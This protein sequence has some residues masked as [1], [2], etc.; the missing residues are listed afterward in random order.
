MFL[1]N[2]VFLLLMIAPLVI[3]LLRKKLKKAALQHSNLGV[4]GGCQ[5]FN[6]FIRLLPKALIVILIMLLVITLAHPQVTRVKRERKL[7]ARE[8]VLTVD[9]SGS[10]D[11]WKLRAVI[12]VGKRFAL[13][14]GEKG[15]LV[16]VVIYGGR[17]AYSMV[18]PTLDYELVAAS[19]DNI[20]GE[21][22]GVMTPIGEG[23][24]M[25]LITL[26]EREMGEDFDLNL[27]RDSLKTEEKLYV[28]GLV[29]KIGRVKNKLIVLF[30]DGKHNSG[31]L[32]PREAFW[33]IRK[34]GVRVYFIAPKSISGNWAVI[35]RKETI[36]TG[37]RYYE[38]TALKEE[39]ISKF[40][41]EINKI[42]K[43]IVVIEEV[44]TKEDF[45][46]PFT[47]AILGV[48]VLLVLFENIWLR[49][50]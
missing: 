15:D 46:W 31:L 36:A 17:V 6:N 30:T 10:M 1:T 48:L 26:I 22:A 32:D 21:K 3:L 38:T 14:R 29:E 12:E 37:G 7:K 2:P 45:Y 23:L 34:L 8:M 27:L 16:G 11:Y 50:E 13:A 39:E 19:L 49:I 28:K 33:L 4:A 9:A 35:C 41:D 43:D 44:T 40:Y 47:L 42:E 25:S 5:G 18:L 24:F 20:M